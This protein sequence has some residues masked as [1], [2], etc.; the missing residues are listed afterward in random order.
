VQFLKHGRPRAILLAKAIHHCPRLR[1]CSWY[2]RYDDRDIVTQSHSPLPNVQA[3]QPRQPYETC[4]SGKPPTA[5]AV[6]LYVH[7]ASDALSEVPFSGG[8]AG[9]P[10]GRLRYDLLLQIG[11]SVTDPSAGY[12]L[13]P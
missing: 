9:M 10:F 8:V 11:P 12:I 5:A 3:Q 13:R 6:G 4:C 1:I 7:F 2:W